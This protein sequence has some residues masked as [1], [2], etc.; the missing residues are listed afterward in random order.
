MTEL[1]LKFALTAKTEHSLTALGEP[2][3]RLRLH[4]I[5]YDTVDGE[6]AAARVALRVRRHGG[7]WVQTVKADRGDA[8]ERLEW[9]RE[10]DGPSPSRDALPPAEDAIGALLHRGFE[11]IR[12]TF[13]TDFERSTRVVA[14]TDGLALEIAR[15]FGEIR[16]GRRR[17]QI[18]EVEIEYLRGPRLG[19]LRW[20][21][22]WAREAQALLVVPSKSERALRLSGRLPRVQPPVKT[23]AAA[24]PADIAPAGAAALV[25]RAC[26]QHA[27]ANLEPI[28]RGEDPGGPHQ[29]R[30]ALRRLRAAIRFFEL[31]ELAEWRA[32][33]AQ[34]AEIAEIAGAV[35]EFDVLEQGLLAELAGHFPTDPAVAALAA[36]LD[37]A[38]TRAR[39]RLRAHLA[40]PA[41]TDFV[42]ATLTMTQTLEV[43]DPAEASSDASTTASSTASTESPDDAHAFACFARSRTLLALATVRRRVR[44]A[45]RAPHDARWHQARIAVKNLRYAIEFSREALASL[46]D[47]KHAIALLSD[48]QDRLG[49]AQDAAVATRI[50]AGALADAG[51]GTAGAPTAR[52]QA[53]IDAWRVMVAPLRRERRGPARRRLQTLREAL[54]PLS[55]ADPHFAAVSG[56][57]PGAADRVP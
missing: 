8:F 29:L 13:E 34:A 45:R 53:L 51:A 5:Y 14:G 46:V 16:C 28:A 17:Q 49:A 48:W 2:R 32:L 31:R 7:R 56:H 36:A 57:A 40:S 19:F 9:E 20:V 25:L 22:A 39:R 54:A 37:S 38:R 44:R 52:A 26:L 12:P 43:R 11:R 15:D 42:L 27:L 35:R 10:I 1:E 55:P 30:V 3:D 47:T 23:G 24:P 41:L 4:S 6:L 33:S 18:R 50:A 21:S